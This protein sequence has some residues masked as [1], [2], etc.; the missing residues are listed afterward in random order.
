MFTNSGYGPLRKLALLASFTVA[1]QFAAA[2]FAQDNQFSIFS[3]EQ[4]RPAAANPIGAPP[5]TAAFTNPNPEGVL[6]AKELSADNV[7]RAGVP[8]LTGSKATGTYAHD[9]RSMFRDPPSTARPALN[10]IASTQKIDSAP[11][12]RS[13]SPLASRSPAASQG[14]W[15]TKQSPVPIADVSDFKRLDMPAIKSDLAVET[16]S[17]SSSGQ[18][19]QVAFQSNPIS[20]PPATPTR[21]LGSDS[22]APAPAPSGS[23]TVR[24]QGSATV[25]SQPS[26]QSFP[27]ATSQPRRFSDSSAPPVAAA[28]G[29]SPSPSPPPS[30]QPQV[31]SFQ[32]GSGS[33]ASSAPQPGR[34]AG[35]QASPQGNSLR[36]STGADRAPRVAALQTRAQQGGGR[37]TGGRSFGN[38]DRSRNTGNSSSQNSSSKTARQLVSQWSATN[39]KTQLAGRPFSLAELLAQPLGV[40]R[41]AAIN[42]YWETWLDLSNHLIAQETAD[43]ISSTSASDE[44]GKNL[45][46]AAQQTARNNVLAT[47]IQLG[48][49]QSKL[50]QFLPNLR[51]P[52]GQKILVLPTDMPWVGKVKTNY[53]TY[54]QRGIMLE[55]FNRIDDILPKAQELI[56]HRAEAVNASGNAAEMARQAA[57]SGRG[58]VSNVLEAT[59]IWNLSQKQL[60][61]S[62]FDYNRAITDYILSVRSDIIQPA[63]L[64]SVLIGKTATQRSIASRQNGSSSTAQASSGSAS[65]SLRP[66]SSSANSANSGLGSS[67]SGSQSSSSASNLSSAGFSRPEPDESPTPSSNASPATGSSSQQKW[68]YG[69]TPETA[70]VANFDPNNLK[71]EG[72]VASSKG[73]SSSSNYQS[74]G[75]AAVAN[76]P[77]A[78]TSRGQS[79]FAGGN[80]RGTGQAPPSNPINTPAAPGA[81]AN[82]NPRGFGGPRGA[83]G[84]FRGAAGKAAPTTSGNGAFPG[85]AAR[86]SPPPTTNPAGNGGN[87]FSGFKTSSGGSPPAAPPTANPFAPKQ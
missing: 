13:L 12:Q 61:S 42:Q 15:E 75:G 6:T 43:W 14:K 73:G 57:S 85:P 35:L 10:P 54:R 55:R 29:F 8:T 47:E 80:N 2:S 24:S 32:S 28:R 20:A 22:S 82:P 60:V 7:L 71:N 52:D 16:E 58:P 66:R 59:R 36:R 77:S 51:G 19:A 74:N 62:I 40:Q 37:S 18:I 41:K 3:V 45:L 67:S 78:A 30:T 21:Q 50:Q 17:N 79:R 44:S 34:S 76:R 27:P 33:Q 83:G 9:G 63:K 26:A 5:A 72:P 11:L 31:R 39:A 64:S 23:A 65:S 86:R 1:S 49:S 87:V 68:D 69:P 84:G 70:K 46:Q 48:K 81:T 4:D 56:D 38:Q 53:Q 25:R